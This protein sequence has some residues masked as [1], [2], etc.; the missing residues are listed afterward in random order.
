MVAGLLCVW[1]GISLA[2]LYLDRRRRERQIIDRRLFS[3]TIDKEHT[4]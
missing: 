3:E 4:P 1:V 2:Q